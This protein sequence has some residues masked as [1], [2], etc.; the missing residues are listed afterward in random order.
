MRKTPLKDILLAESYRQRCQDMYDKKCPGCSCGYI[1][2]L[3]YHPSSALNDRA[4]QKARA[5]VALGYVG[6]RF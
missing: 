2:N 1:L 6:E 3:A 4:G 5:P